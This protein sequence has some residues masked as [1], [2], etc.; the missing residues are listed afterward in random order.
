MSKKELA[1]ERIVINEKPRRWIFFVHGFLGKGQNWRTF[2]H[3]LVSINPDWGAVLVDLR[4][5]G[6][7]QDFSEPHSLTEAA[8]DVLSL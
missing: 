2:A 8:L 7:S 5:H 3:R 1:H 6:K 4:L